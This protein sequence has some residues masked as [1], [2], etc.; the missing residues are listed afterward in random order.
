LDRMVPIV[1]GEHVTTD[2][3]TGNVHTAPAH[4][5]DDYVMAQKY[6][7]PIDNPVDARSCFVKDMPLVAGQHVFKANEPII[8]VL[9]DSGHL[10]HQEKIQH[11]YPHCWRHK[12]PLIF[13][14]TPQWFISME[15]NGLRRM[16]LSAIEEAEWIPGWGETRIRRM[17]ETRPDW[18]I[19]RQR[20]WGTPIAVFV[21]NE[22]GELHPDT[23]ELMQTVAN[24]VEKS[25]IDAWYDLDPKA[26]LGADAENYTKVTDTLDVWF[27]SGVS[28][29]CVLE[30]RAEL[31]VPA[32]LYLEG[33]DQHRGWFHTSLLTSLAIR[34]AAPF[35]TVLTHGYV[36]DAKGHKMSKSVGNTI[37]PPDVIKKLGADILRLWAAATDHTGDVSVSDEILKRISDAYRRIR[38]T[39]RFL[40]SNLN[41]FDPQ[42]K[43]A[44]NELLDLDKWAIEATKRLQT[45]IINAYEHYH[46]Q[47]IY[48]M[49]HN[50]CSVELGSFYLDI[51]K[52]R[53]YTSSKNGIPRR[54]GQTA[55]YYI[56]EALVRWL[57]PV[58]SFTAEEIWRVM[59]GERNA[60]VFLN[61]WYTEF[62]EFDD[63]D[64]QQQYWQWL[65]QVRDAV[66]RELETRRNQGEIG[67]GL[68][69]SITL[70]ADQ[71][72]LDK[73]NSVGDELR[74]ILITSSARVMAVEAKQLSAVETEIPGVWVQVDKTTAQKCVRC[75]Q[76][77]EDVGADAAHPELCGRC[78]L[79]VSGAGEARQY[80]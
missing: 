3:G 73:L 9:A 43:L 59:P 54:S 5:L 36:V 55:M 18:C 63:A 7:L 44:A 15:A 25:G 80:A 52:D 51:I 4:G 29:T 49:I 30:E 39:A 13:R 20:Y 24:Q 8:V 10:L 62:P 57:A 45:K 71:S 41:D 26:L 28:H 58:L 74:F 65:M 35:K 68:D 1:L 69:A 27:D 56:L 21:H 53:Q 37:L 50:F 66:N 48:Q 6:N 32:D 79:N 33:S 22:T 47:S 23:V 31:Y 64:N 78:V 19:S 2:A 61:E 40:L 42:N 16:A 38:N 60:S 70:Y 11:S 17:I 46:F 77:R 12:T 72:A 75:W 76:R 34:N 14:A 67:S